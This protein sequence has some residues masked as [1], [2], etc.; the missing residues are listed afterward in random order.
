MQAIH[1]MN[2]KTAK[3]VKKDYI[4]KCDE[5][6]M[7]YIVLPGS[8]QNILAIIIGYRWWCSRRRQNVDSYTFGKK[9]VLPQSIEVTTNLFRQ[10]RIMSY[11]LTKTINRK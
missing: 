2:V 7:L 1:T 4:S 10:K 9:Y 6:K 5:L 11:A 3:N 8:K